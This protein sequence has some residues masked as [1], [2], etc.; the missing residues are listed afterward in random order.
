[1]II[2]MKQI[3]PRARGQ[4]VNNLGFLCGVRRGARRQGYAP[5]RLTDNIVLS[6]SDFGFFPALL[7]GVG[8]LWSPALWRRF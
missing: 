5:W 7:V 3:V 4:L 8:G 2:K 1:M 6:F